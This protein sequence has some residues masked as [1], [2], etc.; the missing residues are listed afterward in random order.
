MGQALLSKGYKI[1]R[2]VGVAGY[3]IDLAI[4]AEDSSED[5]ISGI[6]CDGWRYHSTP[7][8]RDRDWQRQQVLEGLGWR[9]HRVWSTAWAKN[10]GAEMERIDRASARCQVRD[11]ETSSRCRTAGSRE[12]GR[13]N[14][15]K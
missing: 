14:W 7:P 11:V 12:S 5:T 1:A 9:I 15:R 4:E 13:R 2:Q 3:R 6:E 8:A 10:P